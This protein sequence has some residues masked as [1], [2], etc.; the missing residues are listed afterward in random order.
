MLLLEIA[1]GKPNGWSSTMI[2]G[3]DTGGTFTDFVLLR[4]VNNEEDVQLRTHKVLST[5]MLRRRQFYRAFGK[6]V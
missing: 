5:P 2:L 4:S 3:V 6:W 1:A